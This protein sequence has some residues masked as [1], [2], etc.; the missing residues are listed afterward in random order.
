MSDA[1]IWARPRA[2]VD[3]GWLVVVFSVPEAER[4]KRHEL[5]SLLTRLGFGT[6]AP[7]V[8]VAPGTAYDE[9]LAERVRDAILDLD[10]V[11][12]R[13]MFGGLAFLA[14]GTWR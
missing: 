13:R 6:A 1:R 4:G 12:E 3:D 14:V 9:S 11:S 5:R 8:W 7:G 10:G 2:S